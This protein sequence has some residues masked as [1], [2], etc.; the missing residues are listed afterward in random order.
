MR[1]AGGALLAGA[2]AVTLWGS[3]SHAWVYVV[4]AGIG[5][6]GAALFAY[7]GRRASASEAS[8]DTAA[9]PFEPMDVVDQAGRE[10]FPASDPP[11][12]TPVHLG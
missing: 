12:F 3:W 2:I 8:E 7:G 1:L 9:R 6:A 4:G 10:S 5:L 11:S